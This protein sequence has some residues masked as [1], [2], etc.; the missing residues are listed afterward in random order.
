MATLIMNK[1]MAKMMTR[2][3][4][5]KMTV[6][7]MKINKIPLSNK[8]KTKTKSKSIAST[9]KNTKPSITITQLK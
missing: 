1:V 6:K 8:N 2:M 5:T 7:K 4:T 3:K 9:I